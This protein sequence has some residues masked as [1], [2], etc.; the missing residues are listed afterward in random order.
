MRDLFNDKVEW[1][2]QF[3]VFF[4]VRNI[5]KKSN[6]AL[7][8]KPLNNYYFAFKF[9]FIPVTLIPLSVNAISWLVDL[10]IS[11]S[12]MEG[13]QHVQK[14]KLITSFV[15]NGT[16]LGISIDKK[17]KLLGSFNEVFIPVLASFA[18]YP[19]P[20]FYKYIVTINSTPESRFN[21]QGDLIFLY[22]STLEMLP[23]YIL[24]YFFNF[25]LR[26]IEIFK[27]EIDGMTLIA[28]GSLRI[29]NFALW[30]FM[31]IYSIKT[32]IRVEKKLR[33]NFQVK[34][35]AYSWFLIMISFYLFQIFYSMIGIFLS[36]IFNKI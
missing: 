5:L 26:Y 15:T 34:A 25:Y 24:Y 19:L 7:K 8:Y 2:K 1:I 29:I 28:S 16:I 33:S 30:L 14:N 31:I 21:R 23:L 3:Q 9:F 4:R 10:F 11:D 12:L 36:L 22:Y 20:K 17:I 32:S 27:Q 13:Y 35:N 18:F 6:I